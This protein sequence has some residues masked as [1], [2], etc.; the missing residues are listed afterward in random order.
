MRDVRLG[1]R[2]LPA[3]R[4]AARR[5]I[6]LGDTACRI[7]GDASQACSDPNGWLFAQVAATAAAMKPDLVMHV[8]D[9][10][11]RESPCPAGNAGCAGSP[12]GA[13]RTSRRP[14]PCRWAGRRS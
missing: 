4:A 9:Y 13:T 6:V 8:G 14:T 12:W 7:K 10:H 2:A 1:T 11:Y 3:P 5:I